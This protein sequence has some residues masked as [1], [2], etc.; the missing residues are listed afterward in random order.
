MNDIVSSF[1]SND[2]LLQH[3]FASSFHSSC[4]ED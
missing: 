1:I 2:R 4:L 3:T